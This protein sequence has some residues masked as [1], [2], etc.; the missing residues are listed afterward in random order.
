M[1]Y[2]RLSQLLLITSLTNTQAQISPPQKSI[3]TTY[4]SPTQ[5]L[6][7][8]IP[9]KKA[10]KIEAFL[11]QNAQI[12][13][14]NEDEY[15]PIDIAYTQGDFYL[16]SLLKSYGA[17]IQQERIGNL[18]QEFKAPPVSETFFEKAKLKQECI[19]ILEDTKKAFQHKDQAPIYYSN[20]HKKVFFLNLEHPLVQAKYPLIY[21]LLR[22]QLNALLAYKPMTNP[23][24]LEIIF[25]SEEQNLLHHNAH[26]K[27]TTNTIVFGW[28]YLYNYINNLYTPYTIWRPLAHELQH[29]YQQNHL[30]EI[31]IETPHA[32]NPIELEIDADFLATKTALCDSNHSTTHDLIKTLITNIM[33]THLSIVTSHSPTVLMALAHHIMEKIIILDPLFMHNNLDYIKA[34]L[35]TLI[36]KAHKYACIDHKAQPLSN[37]DYAQN[38]LQFILDNYKNTMQLP[39]IQEREDYSIDHPTAK[40][41]NE[42]TLKTRCLYEIS[43]LKKNYDSTSTIPLTPINAPYL[44]NLLTH[45]LAIAELEYTSPNNIFS[46]P[47]KIIE[48]SQATQ[49]YHNFSY[50]LQCNNATTLQ[51]IT[52]F[53]TSSF[54]NQSQYTITLPENFILFALCSAY[55]HNTFSSTIIQA[56]NATKNLSAINQCINIYPS[57]Q[58]ALMVLEALYIQGLS[59]LPNHSTPFFNHEKSIILFSHIAHIIPE[60]ALELNNVSTQIKITNALAE[61]ATTF[62]SPSMQHNI[63]TISILSARQHNESII[64]QCAYTLFAHISD[65]RDSID[66]NTIT[67]KINPKILDAADK[68]GYQTIIEKIFSIFFGTNQTLYIEKLIEFNLKN[69]LLK[70]LE[71]H[72]LS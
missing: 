26:A 16:V 28:S 54:I 38:I 36:E 13:A 2:L 70:Y 17:N 50:Q 24:G 14:T 57:N 4:E 44:Y 59:L 8:P 68:L 9:N 47:S 42:N 45:N 63:N 49:P 66:L 71:K 46:S 43:L 32:I 41:R 12:E 67:T 39:Y 18:P 48:Y 1:K 29:L 60:L 40:A 20:M 35:Q 22:K 31:E 51:A 53:I 3:T 23:I 5:K 61:I 58:N 11:S 52:P 34:R 65:L 33:Y 19:T 62:L 64:Y 15:Q 21:L 37:I 69:T 6:H 30:A 27:K 56:I 72:N 25:S 10:I 55:P 7:Q